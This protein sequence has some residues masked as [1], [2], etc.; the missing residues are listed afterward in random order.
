MHIN[1]NSYCLGICGGNRFIFELSNSLVELGHKVTITSLG[2]KDEYAWF[3]EP[4]AEITNL[5]YARSTILRA[6]RKYYMRNRGY[7]YDKDLL[8]Q[9]NIPNCDVNVATWCMTTYPTLYSGKGKPVYLVQAYEPD[10]FPEDKPFQT[11]SEL[12]YH[13]PIKKLCVSSWLTSK[14]NGVYIGNGINLKKFTNQKIHRLYDVFVMPRKIATKGTYAPAI[15]NLQEKGF[16]ILVSRDYR[17]SEQELV[18]AYN[19]SKTFL[20]L[21][22]TEGFG[23]PPLEAMACGCVP[24]TTPCVEFASHLQNAWIVQNEEKEIESAITRLVNDDILRDELTQNGL[25]TAQTYDF[26][27]VV[28]AFLSEVAK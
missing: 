10:F 24:V 6:F 1:F 9:K 25:E 22:E 26:Q 17:L 27:N 7:D 12:T 19:Q 8:L 11:K 3:P 23:F 28:K 13:L 4:K 15:R 21:S 14:V 2:T 18:K 20:Y 16:K 5:N